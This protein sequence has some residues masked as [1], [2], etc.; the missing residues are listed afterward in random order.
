[1]E[2]AAYYVVAEALTNIAKYANASTASVTVVQEPEVLEVRVADDGCGG[3]S[4]DRGSGLRGLGDRVA[5]LQG[6]LVV[7][8][9]LGHGTVVT[10]RIPI[11]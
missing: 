8:S 11:Q 3:A 1:V 5:A 2:S 4:I 10:A 6:R 7:E 9:P